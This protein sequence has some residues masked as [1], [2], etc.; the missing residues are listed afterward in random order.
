MQVRPAERSGGSE[1]DH[2]FALFT[3]QRPKSYVTPNGRQAERPIG[4]QRHEATVKAEQL[5][6]VV[7][8]ERCDIGIRHVPTPQHAS[9][10][11]NGVAEAVGQERYQ[12]VY[13]DPESTASAVS[14]VTSIRL[15]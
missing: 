14:D 11:N 13:R 12:G 4:V 8:R 2:A 9:P 3:R 1:F 10:G 7:S 6:P 15:T 5:A